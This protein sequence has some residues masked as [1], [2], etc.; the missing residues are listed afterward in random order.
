M[1]VFI[2]LNSGLLHFSLF[3]SKNLLWS[4]EKIFFIQDFKT[5]ILI[6]IKQYRILKNNWVKQKKSKI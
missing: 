2:I 6:Q 4:G 1:C 3:V 5:E